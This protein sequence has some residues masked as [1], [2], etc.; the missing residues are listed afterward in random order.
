MARLETGSWGEEV[1]S[2]SAR[3]KVTPYSFKFPS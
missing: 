1:G 2:G 3:D